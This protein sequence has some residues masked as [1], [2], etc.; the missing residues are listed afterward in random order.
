LS[1]LLIF[2]C[3]FITQP[4]VDKLPNS[5]HPLWTEFA[6]CRF[7]RDEVKNL[8]M[9]GYTLEVRRL[10]NKEISISGFMIPLESGK[11]LSHFLLNKLNPTCAFCP[12]N[13]PGEIIEVFTTEP[14]EW[15]ENLATFSGK[16]E[17]VNDGRQRIFFL[18]KNAVKNK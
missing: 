12:P 1:C 13:K 10:N 9:I 2:C 8:T 7:V 11:K 18:L 5:N 16:L 17:L 15:H 3:G 4:K 6:K 14:V